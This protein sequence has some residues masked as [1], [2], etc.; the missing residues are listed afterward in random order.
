MKT[1]L[2]KGF[3]KDETAPYQMVRSLM[4]FPESV[5]TRQRLMDSTPCEKG[6]AR[7]KKHPRGGAWQ[8]IDRLLVFPG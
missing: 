7:L 8:K 2:D 4:V 1:Y 5:N 6:V 3:V